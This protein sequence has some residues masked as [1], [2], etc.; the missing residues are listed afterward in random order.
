[1]P[2][3]G[4]QINMNT[5]EFHCDDITIDAV[6]HPIPANKCIPD[7]FRKLPADISYNGATVKRCM[8][9]LDSMTSGYIIPL[10]QDLYFKHYIEDN[11]DRIQ[12]AWGGSANKGVSHA[13]SNHS[14][15]QIKGSPIGKTRFGSIPM[16]FHSPWIIK[17]PPGYSCLITAPLNRYEQDFEIISAI[18]DTDLYFD[19]LNFPFIWTTPNFEGTLKTG[20]PLVQVIPFKRENWKVKV[21]ALN[22]KTSK[23]LMSNNLLR[24]LNFKKLY[25]NMF[26]SKKSYR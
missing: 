19:K 16:K 5:I 9:F 23:K 26:W 18:V 22:H 20:L 13:V 1:M 24:Q 2:P 15:E 8:P 10:W 6:P 12:Y 25:K 17:T 14:Y 7:W 3:C 11:E 21:G 4:D